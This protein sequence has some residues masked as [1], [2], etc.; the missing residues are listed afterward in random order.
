MSRLVKRR[1]ANPAPAVLALVNHGGRKMAAKKRPNT[2]S[3]RRPKSAAVRK[4]PS[5]APYRSNPKK[6]R[7]PRRR[8]PIGTGTIIEGAKLAGSGI[9]IGFVQPMVRSFIGPWLGTSIWG[10]AGVTL[11][12]GYTLSYA[13][14]LTRF[15]AAF[16]R[17]LELATWTIVA[18]QLA[19]SFVLPL[20]RPMGAG[21]NPTMSGRSRRMGD[22]VTLPAGNFDPYYGT[23]PKIAG[24]TVATTPAPNGGSQAATLKGLITMQPRRNGASYYQGR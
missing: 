22:L 24:S 5:R 19:S 3:K 14:K 20:L 2:A 1:V 16:Q 18:T 11:A 23:T 9:I 21:A 12:T 13:S 8:N 10:S 17:P 6:T 15:T 4:S 7:R